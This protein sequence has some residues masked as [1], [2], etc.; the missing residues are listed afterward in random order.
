[1]AAIVRGAYG[2]GT[3]RIFLVSM[4]MAVIGTIAVLFIKE[5]AL[6]RLS[7]EDQRRAAQTAADS[8]DAELTQVLAGENL[9]GMDADLD[10]REVIDPAVEPVD[11]KS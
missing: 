1:I 7:G 4:A 2:D 10:R 9:D 3:A 5:V 6:N 8:A 11:R